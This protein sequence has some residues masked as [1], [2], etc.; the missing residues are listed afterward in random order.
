FTDNAS[1]QNGAYIVWGYNVNQHSDLL[2]MTT[3]GANER[4]A[5]LAIGATFIDSDA[6]VAIRPVAE[7]GVAPHEY[8][9]VQVIF[10]P[11]APVINRQPV[12][13]IV[14]PGQTAVFAV[15]A[16][17]IPA[18]VYLWQRQ[19]KG[20]GRWTGLQDGGSCSGD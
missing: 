4:D 7:G 6:S 18:P 5:T 8:L 9:D 19:A 15:A 10:D 3:P 14:T 2:D 13:Q 17:S 20:S 12:D 1:M 16:A 11:V